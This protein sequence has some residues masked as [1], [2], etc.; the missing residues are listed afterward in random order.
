M[1]YYL[2]G[3]DTVTRDLLRKMSVVLF[4]AALVA[5]LFFVCIPVEAQAESDYV[6]PLTF[7]TIPPSDLYIQKGDNT[8]LVKYFK[9]RKDNSGE[10]VDLVDKDTKKVKVG[11]GS[12]YADGSEVAVAYDL[13]SGEEIV[14]GPV[15]TG[16]I[17]FKVDGRS[18]STPLSAEVLSKEYGDGSRSAI[19]WEKTEN[20][21]TIVVTFESEGLAATA[22]PGTY[23]LS[24][25][26][27]TSGGVNVM[28]EY[29]VTPK[30]GNTTATA[31][32]TV[33]AKPLTVSFAEEQSVPFN[34]FIMA[35]ETESVACVETSGVNGEIVT[36]YFRLTEADRGKTVLSVGEQYTVEY[37][38]HTVR[39]GEGDPVSADYYSVT[40]D[41]SSVSTVRA[42]SGPITLY[43]GDVTA[44]AGRADCV[45]FDISDFTY[46]YLDE[47]VSSYD[48]ILRFE[49]VQLY[50]G[51][52]VDLRCSIVCDKSVIPCGT[53]ALTLLGV[54]Q[55]GFDEVA[56]ASG[57]SMIVVPRVLRYSGTK[58]C[59]YG[60]KTFQT[61]V[62]V[63]DPDSETEYTFTLSASIV[64]GTAVGESVAYSG[65]SAVSKEDTGILLDYS[66]ARVSI[67]RRSDGVSFR[68]ADDLSAVYYHAA[69]TVGTL[70]LTENGKMTTL[71]S[72]D[73]EYSYSINGGAY[74]SGLPRVVGTY[75]VKS[76]LRSTSS[77]IAEEAIFDLVIV[78]CPVLA[79]YRV[80][81]ASKRY[82]E[83][84][85]FASETMLLTNLY[86]YNVGSGTPDRTRDYR[87]APYNETVSAISA[88]TCAGAAASAELGS[89][90][91][92][93][94][95]KTGNFDVKAIL[96]YDKST[97][98]ETS[99]LTVVQG[100][101]P[102]TTSV[103]A[104]VGTGKND[105]VIDV[106]V[107][108]APAI[109]QISEKSDFS[110]KNEVST[111]DG[112]ASF[113]NRKY[114]QVY[115][116]RACLTDAVRYENENGE[117]SEVKTVSVSLPAPTVTLVEGS[118]TD[119]TAEFT[120]SAIS[121]AA[122]YVLE[123]RVG[124]S[125]RWTEGLE[126]A[127]LTPGAKQTVYFRAK[128]AS[129]T[130]QETSVSLTAL[131]APVKEDAVSVSYDRETGALTITSDAAVEMRLLSKSGEV[132]TDWTSER[133]LDGVPR[134][135]EYILQVRNAVDGE[136]S[137]ITE[138]ETDTYR[139]GP[140]TILTYL[141]DWFL[142]WIGGLLVVMLVV[143]A[144]LFARVK[145]NMD[146]RLL[147]G[148]DEK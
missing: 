58:E 62:K 61:D 37:F 101:R 22:V 7:D 102:P 98:I 142:V 103:T 10:L 65:T 125:G 44:Y 97:T 21:N 131:C 83:T 46:T 121:N 60:Y 120:A 148:K 110:V 13:N 78:P 9:G 85:R 2:T 48:N 69:Y 35:G 90:P 24:V 4:A 50:D 16:R 111:S 129:V 56:L 51:V 11:K 147:G 123:Y 113:K 135:A 77:Y 52:V 145:R 12:Y 144:I 134:D 55:E 118:I 117:W 141:S 8:F 100:I 87:A 59:Q 130:G 49:D 19:V 81:R 88:I 116:V 64:D 31:T 66:E 30:V 89:Y 6:I 33:T 96:L 57:F 47:F 106:T 143:I 14:D 45:Q 23:P 84:Y 15:Y 73:I 112:N 74:T 82:G 107:A 79:V 128:A 3:V 115:Y 68:A 32:L 99:M 86:F 42:V 104:K 95:L 43:Q 34:N 126:V 25:K 109:V 39:D 36:A 140:F 5:L 122:N 76:T 91:V 71:P 105:R 54:E 136:N 38:K 119:T 139:K 137:V 63:S 40:A 94:S 18:L 124:S 146:R 138:I 108:S 17:V 92:T 67:V 70:T 20:E 127:G 26:S 1:L 75:K 80:E 27:V 53:Y 132:I 41:L 72:D 114:G 93:V 133:V 29:T 28:D